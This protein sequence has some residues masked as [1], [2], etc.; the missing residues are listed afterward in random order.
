MKVYHRNGGIEMDK[1]FK[2]LII[3]A[4]S[5]ALL[6]VPLSVKG[7]TVDATY[8]RTDTP[9]IGVAPYRQ[10]HAHSTGNRASTALN[11]AMYMYRK[12]LS[13]GYY[14]YVVGNGKVYYTA[15]VNRG[16]WDVGN[17]YNYETYAGVVLIESHKTQTDFNRD[18]AIYVNLLRDLAIQ[19]GIPITYN[20][21]ELGGIKGHAY[22]NQMA[23]LVGGH[24]DPE[25][26]LPLWGVSMI[27]FAQDLQTG[28]PEDGSN[29]ITPTPINPQPG[30]PVTPQPT[31]APSA[32]YNY[33]AKDFYATTDNAVNVRTAQNT[34]ASI[35]RELPKG[36][37]VHITAMTSNGESVDGNP[38]W[39]EVENA[40]W[41]SGQNITEIAAPSAPAIVT[42]NRQVYKV[43]STQYL[44]GVWQTYSTELVPVD[45]TW[46]DNGIALADVDWCD[47]NGN[48]NINQNTAD[49]RYFKIKAENVADNHVGGYG[50]GG[51]YWRDIHTANGSDVWQ[52][53][54]DVGDL[55][56]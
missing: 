52:S 4:A 20:T 27:K 38:Y 5:T 49:G 32:S 54:W 24:T 31:P 8:L 11:E 25:N 15:P 22:T 3:L 18:Y 40:G 44:H 48:T 21:P 37:T 51:Y 53:V 56:Y 33:T 28:L 2:S 9:Q 23:G 50:S 39:F 10:I 12:D 26:Y 6:G 46:Y 47:A 34:G 55:V 13:G 43:A 42:D 41:V 19:A 17:K 36:T 45:F 1:K 7:Y 30:A 29:P 14:N 16:A 35:V